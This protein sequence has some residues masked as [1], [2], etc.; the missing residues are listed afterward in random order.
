[1]SDG[2]VSVIRVAFPDSV[3]YILSYIWE[4]VGSLYPFLNSVNALVSHGFR[5]IVFFENSFS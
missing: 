2:F 5:V 1:M 4:V 3:F